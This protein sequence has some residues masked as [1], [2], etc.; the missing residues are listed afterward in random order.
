[1]SSGK[2]ALY[3]R[4]CDIADFGSKDN[5]ASMPANTTQTPTPITIDRFN[6]RFFCTI[7]RPL[8]YGDFIEIVREIIYCY[9]YVDYFV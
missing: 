6:K 8:L 7:L 5:H 2:K 4:G 3:T 1:M 9:F